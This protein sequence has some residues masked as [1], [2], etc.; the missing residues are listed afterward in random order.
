MM[1]V[2]IRINKRIHKR[3]KGRKGLEEE[4]EE[5]RIRGNKGD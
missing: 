2:G 5:K 3:I 1:K 4:Y